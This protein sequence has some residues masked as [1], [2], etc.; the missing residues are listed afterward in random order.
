MLQETSVYM[1]NM[2]FFMKKRRQIFDSLIDVYNFPTTIIGNEKEE[3]NY[4][5]IWSGDDRIDVCDNW[6]SLED[7]F[8][9]KIIEENIKKYIYVLEVHR[10]ERNEYKVE[11]LEGQLENAKK[12]VDFLNKIINAV[13]ESEL[14][15]NKEYHKW[16]K[17]HGICTI[18]EYDVV[19]PQ[20]IKYFGHP[21]QYNDYNEEDLIYYSELKNKKGKV[22]WCFKNLIEYELPE[23]DSAV[24][25][26]VDLSKVKC[27]EISMHGRLRRKEDKSIWVKFVFTYAI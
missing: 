10:D 23:E 16:I 24:L 8:E 15:C 18:D 1:K 19:D 26:T 12:V 25:R 6:L 2:H 20:M 21:T 11:I 3:K 27:A 9:V 17:N 22:Y 14:I 13:K 4:L 5:S 7:L